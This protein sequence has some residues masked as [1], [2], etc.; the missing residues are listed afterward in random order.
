MNCC[1]TGLWVY[2]LHCA[3]VALRCPT[4]LHTCATCVVYAFGTTGITSKVLAA[5]RRGIRRIVL[6]YLNFVRNLEEI[7]KDVYDSIEFIPVRSV[8]EVLEATLRDKED[9]VISSRL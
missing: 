8:D 6:P 5:Y 1:I 3:F 9:V 4:I 2:A 7:P